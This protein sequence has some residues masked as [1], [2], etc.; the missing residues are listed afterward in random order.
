MNM[1][2][3]AENIPTSLQGDLSKKLIGIVLGTQDKDAISTELA[4]KI[5]Y[6]WRQDQL[7][8][9]TGLTA[10][11]EAATTIDAQET[12]SVLDELGL[13]EVTV[14]LKNI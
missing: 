1:E 2:S 8:T 14:A 12:Y 13:Q 3:L 7:A 9:P 6:L 10:L 11:L 5:I 4:K